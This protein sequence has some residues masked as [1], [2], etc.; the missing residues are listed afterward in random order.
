MVFNFLVRSM[1]EYYLTSNKDSFL[2]ILLFC[3]QW[4]V[5]IRNVA[6]INVFNEK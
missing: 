6:V 1:V 5:N 4:G 2:L 3:Y